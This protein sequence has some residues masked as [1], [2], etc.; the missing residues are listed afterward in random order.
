MDRGS[1][2]AR[3]KRG[4]LVVTAS[5]RSIGPTWDEWP[6]TSGTKDWYEEGEQEVAD[7]IIQQE[8]ENKEVPLLRHQILPEVPLLRHLVPPYGSRHVHLENLRANTI[9]GKEHRA[10]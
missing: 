8:G 5:S 2:E 1:R 9:A 4:V 6:T 10:K 3:K 7:D